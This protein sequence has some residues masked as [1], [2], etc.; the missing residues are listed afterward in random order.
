VYGDYQT[1][2]P[3]RFIDEIPPQLME[4]VPSAMSFGSSHAYAAPRGDR[5]AGYGRR[6][7]ERRPRIAT[8]TKTSRPERLEGRP[9]RA[10]I[11]RSASAR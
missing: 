9:A 11:R 6:R 4:T 1:T 8:R 5:W 3:S 10:S 2:E 7:K